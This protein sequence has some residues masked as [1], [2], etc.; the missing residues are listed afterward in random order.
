MFS[1]IIV[2]AGKSSRMQGIDKQFL[3]LNNLPVILHSVLKF[4]NIQQVDEIIIVTCENQLENLK[5]LINTRTFNKPIKI[6]TGS[7][8]RQKS[9][10]SGISLVNKNSKYIAIHDGAR[11]FV[12]EKIITDCFNNAIKYKATTVGVPVKDTIKI[13]NN[14]FIDS[15]PNRSSLYITQTPQ[16]F[17]KQIYFTAMNNAVKNDLDFTDDCQLVESIGHKV[18]MSKGEY[19]NIK[20]TTPEDINLAKFIYKENN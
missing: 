7:D 5:D 15:T 8:T 16:V 9:V 13:V 17:D 12:S 11:P 3:L 6:T 14:N 20:I 4:D 10:F 1:V 2:S 18:Y 19:S